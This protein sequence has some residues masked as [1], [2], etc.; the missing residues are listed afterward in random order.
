MSS[1]NYRFA[2]ANGARIE[3]FL[4]RNCAMSPRQFGACY[5]FISTVSLC[6]GAF[7]WAQ[8][9]TLVL[10]FSALEI[11]VVGVGFLCFARR[12]S[13]R[14]SI[15]IDGHRV[16]VECELSGVIHQASFERAWLSVECPKRPQQL[17]ELRGQGQVIKVGR[18][19]RP[20]WRTAL[21]AEIRH[22]AR[23]G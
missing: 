1:A 2:T 12:A 11:I 22:G 14:E 4:R 13:D 7:F 3:W 8:G 9:A 6:I 21:A 10:P 18:F 16:T 19:V 15:R 5:G 20:E 17:I 23:L